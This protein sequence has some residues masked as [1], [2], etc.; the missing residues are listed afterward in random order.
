VA[1]VLGD[2]LKYL[3]EYLFQGD[4]SA[5]CFEVH[6]EAHRVSRT[7]AEVLIGVAS[8]PPSSEEVRAYY[9]NRSYPVFGIGGGGGFSSVTLKAVKSL[10]L[11][12]AAGVPSTDDGG[13]SGDI[14]AWFKRRET[15][16]FGV[17]DL[18]GIVQ[19]SVD[20]RGKQAILAFRFDGEPDDLCRAVITRI[21]AELARPTY[22][23]SSLRSAPDL[24]SFVCD[25]L[26][27]ARLIDD[28]FRRGDALD[29]LP[30]KSTSIRNLNVLSAYVLCGYFGVSENRSTM[31]GLDAL[32]VLVKALGANSQIIILPVTYDECC[33]FVD[34]DQPIPPSLAQA[35]HVPSSAI[36]AEGHRLFGQ[37]LIDKL[38]QR[39]R[40]LT[41][42]VVTSSFDTT[43]KPRPNPEYLARIG[44][45][46]LFIMGA[47]SLFGS[48]LAQLAV[49]GV[50]DAIVSRQ[51]IRR[52]LVLNHVR[53]DETY[54]MT[55]RDQ[56]EAVETVATENASYA[57]LERMQ[58]G[59]TTHAFARLRISDL[60]TDIVIPRTVAREIEVEMADRGYTGIHLAS[61]PPSFVNLQ[62]ADGSEAVTVFRNRYVDFLLQNPDVRDRL[63]ITLQEI[64]VLSYMDQPSGLHSG[65][66]ESGR[67]R[68]ALFATDEDIRYLL[69]RGIQRRNIHE[70]ESIGENWK[71]LKAEGAPSLEFFPG[72]VSEALV[73]IIK[74]SLERGQVSPEIV[75]KTP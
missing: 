71:I 40:R 59:C 3:T 53:M 21:A 66:R 69:D 61:D 44:D 62:P 15:F 8:T 45:A 55:L 6:L 46:K 68:G 38:P 25:Q 18:A 11:A 30:V 7:I 10:G 34:Y 37:C 65:R 48:Q 28:K 14:Q 20:N 73:G 43:Q 36:Q 52:I 31:N 13:S 16:V 60:F 1:A 51:D 4:L 50:V 5:A 64:R 49:P 2:N 23:D 33:L 26:N 74:I 42:G 39:G 29:P 41:A 56:I 75:P 24:L 19:D 9:A 17:G 35:Y 67:Y 47:G 22:P 27:L 58:S 63:G 57:T 72:L 54:D 12:A 32:Y 70:L